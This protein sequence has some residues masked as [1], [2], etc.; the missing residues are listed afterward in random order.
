MNMHRR[1]LAIVPELEKDGWHRAADLASRLGVSTRTIYRDL[2]ALQHEGLPIVAV[3]GRGYRLSE[4][5]L[6]PP[7]T[8]TADEAVVL[9]RSASAAEDRLGVIHQA[10]AL[11]VRAKLTAALPER[12]RAEALTLQAALQLVPINLFDDPAEQAGIEIL[13]R[14]LAER[15]V[16]GCTLRGG[17]AKALEP[18]AL[19]HVAGAWKLIGLDRADGVVR[20]Y[21]VGDMTE[22]RLFVDNFE[23]PQAYCP[24][25]ETGRANLDITVHV[26]FRYPAAYWVK[27]VPSPHVV[28]M[29]DVTDG[30]LLVLRV[31]REAALMPW[32]LGWGAHAH[33]L[34]PLSL[35]R[36]LAAEASA[37]AERY[38][39]SPSFLP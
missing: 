2:A 19:S 27:Q 16:I 21:H 15:R 18:Y 4:D 17:C 14:A 9:L 24:T 39:G 37:V 29:E 26:R 31:E 36:R 20:H 28:S 6:L 22:L 12:L 32:L 34:S 8:L 23:R 25:R 33:V 38:K 30:L 3:P 11:S 5:F 7:V 35:Q 1:R 13:R 10:A